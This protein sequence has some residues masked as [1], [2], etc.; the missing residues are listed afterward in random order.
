MT[1]KKYNFSEILYKLKDG[2]IA[3]RDSNKNQL[4][5]LE[6]SSVMIFNMKENIRHS[7]LFKNNEI[8]AEDWMCL[9]PYSEIDKIIF[10]YTANNTND[11]NN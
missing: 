5:Y 8:F 3:C 7:H 2:Y 11:K 10:I 9:G 1:D 6:N 4:F